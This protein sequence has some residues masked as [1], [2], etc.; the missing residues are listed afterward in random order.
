MTNPN[1]I[2]NE[3]ERQAKIIVALAPIIAEMERDPYKFALE[4]VKMANK[5]QLLEAELQE[6]KDKHE[7][8]CE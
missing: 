1:D 4:T 8:K 7:I 3:A 5:I 2:W 6:L